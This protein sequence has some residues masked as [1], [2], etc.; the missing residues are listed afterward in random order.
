MGE[1]EKTDIDTLD[2]EIAQELQADE[3]EYTESELKAIDEGWNPDKSKLPEGTKFYNA[4]EYL[5]R[6]TFFRKIDDLKNRNERLEAQFGHLSD[7]YQ[8]ANE[9]ELKKAEAEHKAV[10]K[11]LKA[12]K[13]EA[14]NEGDHQRVVDIDE[15]MQQT[16]EPQAPAPAS[17]PVGDETFTD[18]KTDN[19]WYETDKVLKKQADI[20]SDSYRGTGTPFETVLSEIT[21]DLKDLYPH[22][23]ENPRRKAVG[24]VEAGGSPQSRA[25]KLSEKS[26]TKEEL[27]MY[28][29]LGM[30]EVLKTDAQKKEYFQN[31]IDARES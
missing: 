2:A 12:E 19:P 8:K 6:G 4:E 10:I 7:N 13:V 31:T 17:D 27:S 22:K 9:R 1:A 5:D 26:L 11:A 28:R 30:D 3:P 15:Q 21:A 29:D 24:S 16:I 23:F 18:W 20:M 14:L 25:G